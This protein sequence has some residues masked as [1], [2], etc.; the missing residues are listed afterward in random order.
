MAP[1][2]QGACHVKRCPALDHRPRR[3]GSRAGPRPVH[4]ALAGTLKL[5]ANGHWWLFTDV[6]AGAVTQALATI[7]ATIALGILVAASIGLLGQST[8]WRPQSIVGALFSL[9]LV[10]V[11][12]DGLTRRST[13]TG[14][15]CDSGR[16]ARAGGRCARV[17]SRSDRS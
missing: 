14:C 9:A 5:Q 2:D 16:T 15:L 12:R 6:L 4:A 13:G 1:R 3:A 17:P 8:W 11:M 7:V 10:V